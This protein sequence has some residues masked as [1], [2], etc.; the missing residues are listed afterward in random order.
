[1]RVAFLG[2][3]R[4]GRL[5]AS[6]VLSAGHELTIWNRTPGKA[7]ELVSRGAREA[8]SVEEA[9]KQADAVVMMLFGGES[10]HDV[11][12]AVSGSAPEGALVIDATTTG[13]EAARASA[14]KAA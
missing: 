6:H 1:M 5:M 14:A 13:P 7:D 12:D 10:S 3:G 9:V 2:M 4:M 8:A 11:L